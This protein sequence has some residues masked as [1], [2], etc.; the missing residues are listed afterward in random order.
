[1]RLNLTHDGHGSILESGLGGGHLTHGQV[2]FGN[3]LADDY[4]I[5]RRQAGKVGKTSPQISGHAIG[6]DHDTG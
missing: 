5:Y 6:K 1:M 4:G 3:P 2:A